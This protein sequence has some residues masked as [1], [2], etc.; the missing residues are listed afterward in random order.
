MEASKV[1]Q[2]RLSKSLVHRLSQDPPVLVVLEATGGY[3]MPAV[4]ALLAATIPVAVVNPRQV[5]DFAKAVGQLARR[6]A[7][8]AA[9]LA[10]FALSPNWS[11]QLKSLC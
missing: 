1:G 7:I 11:E 10:H 9:V 3:E 5:R 2:F 6:S 8:D 4:G